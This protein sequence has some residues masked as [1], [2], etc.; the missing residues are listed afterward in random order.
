MK[1]GQTCKELLRQGRDITF[2]DGVAYDVTDFIRLHPGGEVLRSVANGNDGTAMYYSSH[3]TVPA[4]DRVKG[5][6]RLDLSP[7]ECV[8]IPYRFNNDPNSF[9]VELKLAIRDHFKSH[10]IAYWK[11]S[12]TARFMLVANMVAFFIAMYFS[13]VVGITGFSL[14]MGVLSWH[15]AGVLVH[16]H[17]AHRTLADRRNRWANTLFTFLNGLTFPGAFESHFFYSHAGHH[18][19][20][21]HPVLDSDDHLIYPLVRWSDARPRYWF[22]RYQHIYW[23]FAYMVY[24]SAYIAKTF[25]RSRQVDWWKR[26]NHSYRARKSLKFRLL[27]LQWL[28]FHVAIPVIMLGWLGL[29]NVI[30]FVLSYSVGALLFATVSHLINPDGQIR[31]DHP[32]RDQWAYNVVANSGDY[33][34]DSTF[35]YYLSG[36]FNIHGLHH[37]LPAIH[38]SHLR[39]IYFIY[40]DLC[41]RH[42]YPITEMTGIRDLLV[43][44]SKTM[45]RLGRQDETRW[46][47]PDITQN[48]ETA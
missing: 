37:L 41:L 17:G 4:P 42:G 21:H 14:V 12:K 7:D 10:G 36:G 34:V 47:A 30:V 29:L 2:I 35:W 19:A 46:V 8:R 25:S 24:L 16:D 11:P 44:F 13:Y 33:K 9:Y 22:H 18:S 48:S 20:V 40:R 38:P 45:R 1:Q 28:V 31:R 3:F 26:H 23:P 39:G 32:D 5:V 6:K 27:V 15:F 43:A